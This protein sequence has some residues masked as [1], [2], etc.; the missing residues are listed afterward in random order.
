M[1]QVATQ[2]LDKRIDIQEKTTHK[3]EYYEWV[4]DW[5]T[6][7]SIWCSVKEQYFKDYKESLG[8]VLED[9]TNFIIRY[10][11]HFQI[12]NSMRV[13]YNGVNYD[14]VQVL[15]GSFQRDFTTLVCK[16]VKK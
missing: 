5:E 8:T 6:K 10:E 7:S 14:I 15:E 4:T 12:D 16:R 2:R 9:T 13:V 11:Q 3:N 1:A